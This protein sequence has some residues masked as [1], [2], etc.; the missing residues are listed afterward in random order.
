MVY[1]LGLDDQGLVC[2]DGE[3]P[4][5]NARWSPA[6]P[7]A[8]PID[9]IHVAPNQSKPTPRDPEDAETHRC[10]CP[11]CLEI[12]KM[13][14]D[15]RNHPHLQPVVNPYCKR[16][17]AGCEGPGSPTQC[18]YCEG[19]YKLAPRKYA[20]VRHTARVPH[21]WPGEETTVR[22]PGVGTWDDKPSAVGSG[23]DRKRMETKEEPVQLL[24]NPLPEQFPENDPM[25][26]GRIDLDLQAIADTGTHLAGKEKIVILSEPSEFVAPL[27]AQHQF[28]RESNGPA[29]L[30]PQ[31]PAPGY[32]QATGD[33][34]QA[35]G[36]V[37]PSGYYP[38]T[39][40]QSTKPYPPQ[41]G[42]TPSRHKSPQNE[43]ERFSQPQA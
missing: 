28:R 41:Q 18:S 30:P 29:F 4:A 12:K 2:A 7:T 24:P 31:P 33:R 5:P 14:G 13:K 42:G 40:V 20:R 3:P 25:L 37:I 21:P 9:I 15:P 34:R 17:R 36:E 19:I 16:N 35:T 43:R 39:P 23:R 27:L 6:L 11:I 1:R 32:Q 22:I 26:R 8:S 38:P 10:D